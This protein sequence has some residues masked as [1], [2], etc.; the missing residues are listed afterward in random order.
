MKASQN[1]TANGT[2]LQIS[3]GLNLP[4]RVSVR[5]EITPISGSVMASLKRTRSSIVPSAAALIPMTSV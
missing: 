2:A 3:Q 4:Q 1:R 5:S